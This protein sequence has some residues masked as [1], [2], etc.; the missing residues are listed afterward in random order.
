MTQIDKKKAREKVHL[1]RF[2]ECWPDF[3]AGEIRD[4][5]EPDFIVTTEG[6]T[7]GIELRS[8]YYDELKG[9]GSHS[10]QQESLRTQT[11]D[12]AARR[13]QDK[14]LPPVNVSVLWN[15]RR[16]LDKKLV[17]S[18]EEPLFNLVK[19]NLPEPRQEVFLGHPDAT[20]KSL[21]KEIVALWIDRF[22]PPSESLWSSQG[23]GAIPCADVE[24][25]N[26]AILAKEKKIP[27]YRRSAADLATA[28]LWLLVIA[29]GFTASGSCKIAPELEDHCFE[30]SFDRLFFLHYA[31][32][33][34]LELRRRAT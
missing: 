17:K 20:W 30:T 21:P 6:T 10:Q 14:G 5:E 11:V 22:G 26:Q 3:P 23:G 34:A 7:V 19:E 9:K 15:D 18:L 24:D 29:S 8:F 2:R 4:H 16:P 27:A 1:Q 28:E 31:E 33:K 12:S 13:Y 32:G 25:I